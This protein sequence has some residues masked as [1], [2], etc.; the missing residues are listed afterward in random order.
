MRE[1]KELLKGD[2]KERGGGKEKERDREEK[3]KE[4]KGGRSEESE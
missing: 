2:E 4:K 3:E 1:R